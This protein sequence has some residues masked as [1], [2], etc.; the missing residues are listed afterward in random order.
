MI[1][2]STISW[3]PNHNNIIRYRVSVSGIS[4]FVR[5]C[6][7]I[8]F[9]YFCILLGILIIPCL[10]LVVCHIE[11]KIDNMLSINIFSGCGGISRKN[12]QSASFSPFSPLSL[13]IYYS[14]SSL[15]KKTAKEVKER[16][17]SEI[18]TLKNNLDTSDT[19]SKAFQEFINGLFQA[20]GT[21]GVSFPSKESLRIVFNFAIGQNYSEEAALTFLRLQAFLGI[22]RIKVEYDAFLGKAHIRY[23]VTNTQEI[24]DK[25]V[26]YFKFIYGQKRFGLANLMKI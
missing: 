22:G 24:L 14:S 15:S 8:G 23:V 21:V 26:P 25:V 18:E 17:I 1:F 6:R 11:N 20:E 16:V 13:K 5:G 3:N 9:V 10:S 4:K 2:I 7:M 19:D 12:V